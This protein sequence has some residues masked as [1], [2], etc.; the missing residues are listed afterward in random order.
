MIIHHDP[1]K[2]HGRIRNSVVRMRLLQVYPRSVTGIRGWWQ[3][4]VRTG[5]PAC[6][7]ARRLFRPLS[8]QLAV[9]LVLLDLLTLLATGCMVNPGDQ[10]GSGP[11]STG[12]G[13]SASVSVTASP[14]ASGMSPSPSP[15]GVVSN[16]T[17]DSSEPA[18]LVFKVWDFYQQ[19]AMQK[20]ADL[21]CARNPGI[22]ITTDVSSWEEY[23]IEFEVAVA[24]NALPDVF[25]MHRNEF[26]KYAA[27]NLLLDLTDLLD[28]ADSERGGY[29]NFAPEIVASYSFKN[30]IYGVPKDWDTVALVYNKT[31]FRKAGEAFPT[32]DWTWQ[33]LVEVAANIQRKTG[34]YGFAAPYENQ[35]GFYN[36]VYQAGGYVVENGKAGHSE[37]AGR[38]AIHFWHDLMNKYKVSP[39]YSVLSAT[40]MNALFQQGDVAMQF[41]GSW[42]ILPYSRNSQIASQFDLAVLP[43]CPDP[44]AGDG[45]ATIR[46]SLAYS[47]YRKGRHPEAARKF[48]RFLASR[49]ANILQAESGAAIPAFLGT[50]EVWFR[51]YPDIHVEV[52]AEM[53][54][55]A[56]PLPTSRTK[57]RWVVIETSNLSQVYLEGRDLDEA[58]DA[59]DRA[60]EQLL[61]IEN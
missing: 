2:V 42:N 30:K 49:E 9:L 43:R 16:H 38:K 32:A 39:D 54:A 6:G 61:A 25:W 53:L 14:G 44:L 40:D 11:A 26:E 29:A 4:F 7:L 47:A 3:S 59:T 37:P 56:R 12:P 41:L 10:T 21:F 48:L 15:G 50:E 55:Y 35:S 22:V 19:A 33:T 24:A 5:K 52:F 34:K 20:L 45:R 8:R 46:N 36:L 51:Q 60:I 23:W 27:N 18:R 17:T 57:S 28:T 1:A 13:S 58:I 31:L